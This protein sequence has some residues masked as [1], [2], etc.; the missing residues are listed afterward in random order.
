MKQWREGKRQL[1]K[2]SLD[3]SSHPKPGVAKRHLCT[4]SPVKAQFTLANK[5]AA[6]TAYVGLRN[7]KAEMCA[8]AL[9]EMVGEGSK[10]RFQYLAWDRSCGHP[11]TSLRHPY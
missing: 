4:S 1:E 9:E 5:R 11:P 8:Y 10:F 7:A 3:A 2:A 6:A